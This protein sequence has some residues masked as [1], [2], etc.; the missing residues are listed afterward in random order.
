M[1]SLWFL[2]AATGG[3]ISVAIMIRIW[4]PDPPPNILGRFAA[5]LVAGVVGGL[6]GGALLRPQA[7]TPMPGIAGAVL[8]DP[9]PGIIGAL[10]VGLILSGTVAVLS[11]RRAGTSH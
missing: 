5:I 8:A 1:E 4:L 3:A 2:W 9:M 6:L 11:G 7:S 10:A